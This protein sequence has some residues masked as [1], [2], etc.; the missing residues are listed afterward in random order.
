MLIYL[1]MS[2]CT[3]FHSMVNVLGGGLGVRSIVWYLVYRPWS[4]LR[5]YTTMNCYT[6]FWILPL[7]KMVLEQ[8]R[9][10]LLVFLLTLQDACKLSVPC[11]S[12]FNSL[13]MDLQINIANVSHS[14]LASSNVKAFHGNWIM[15]QL[16]QPVNKPLTSF[17]MWITDAVAYCKT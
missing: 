16:D 15:A 2:S 7:S 10:I 11:I 14:E 6:G 12:F 8:F 17:F 13:G 3:L 1:S 9:K 5:M 4:L